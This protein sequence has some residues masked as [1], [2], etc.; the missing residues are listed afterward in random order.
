MYWLP[1]FWTSGALHGVSVDL[2][3][4]AISTLCCTHPQVILSSQVDDATGGNSSSLV[5][6]RAGQGRGLPDADLAA[7]LE[8]KVDAIACPADDAGVVR[9]ARAAAGSGIG[10]S[11]RLGG[12]QGDGHKGP[13]E[14]PEL[15][16][17][18][19]WNTNAGAVTVLVVVSGSPG[20]VVES[21]KRNSHF[22]GVQSVL[23]NMSLHPGS[24]ND[25]I[26]RFTRSYNRRLGP[27]AGGF[28]TANAL[29]LGLWLNCRLAGFPF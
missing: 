11:R 27:S 21:L 1:T 9:P 16:H 15:H 8:S 18:G 17:E 14:A 7:R 4:I 12:Q 26:L 6:P 5:H 25:P 20:V 29:G 24:I 23:M 2:E 3:L 19:C 28:G 13:E 22:P 10:V